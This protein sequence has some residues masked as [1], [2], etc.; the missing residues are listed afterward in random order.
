MDALS[1]RREMLVLSSGPPP[2][3][4][5]YDKLVF[6]GT[7]YIT[8]DIVPAANSSFAA[9][10][11]GETYVGLQ[12][13]FGMATGSTNI[14]VFLNS[15]TTETTRQFSA[16]YASSSASAANKS[17]AFSVSR[18][19]MCLTPRRFIVYGSSGTFTG[20]STAPTTPIT[21]GNNQA[22]SA[23]SYSGSRNF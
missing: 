19:A 5:F 17:V 20:G 8:T 3:P 2:T 14:R 7:A 22:G 13:V 4:E 10:L 16:Y 23:H 12:V 18:Y 21:I 15:N 11:G 1:R 6:D 9:Y